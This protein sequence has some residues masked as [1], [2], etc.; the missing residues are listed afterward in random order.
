MFYVPIF[1]NSLAIATFL[2][3]YVPISGNRFKMAKNRLQM[4]N[5]AVCSEA[6]TKPPSRV[7]KLVA[8]VT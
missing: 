7:N 2:V 8:F 3:I 6:G 5:S 4:R 1:V